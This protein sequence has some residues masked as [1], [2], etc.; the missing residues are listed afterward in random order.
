MSTPLKNQEQKG[1][2]ATTLSSLAT[3]KPINS[4]SRNFIYFYFLYVCILDIFNLYP[5][6]ATTLQSPPTPPPQHPALAPARY[7]QLF[8]KHF[9]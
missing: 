3:D 6:D 2:F 9:E 8:L 1:D 4:T 5:F 7:Q